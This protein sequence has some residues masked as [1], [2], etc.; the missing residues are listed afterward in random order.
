MFSTPGLRFRVVPLRCP[1]AVHVSVPFGV[2]VSLAFLELLAAVWLMVCSPWWRWRQGAISPPDGGR[3]VPP[4]GEAQAQPLGVPRSPDPAKVRSTFRCPLLTVEGL[5][6]S[7]RVL[8]EGDSA[9]PVIGLARHPIDRPDQARAG[10]TDLARRAPTSGRQRPGDV[11]CRCVNCLDVLAVRLDFAC[12]W[13]SVVVRVR[14]GP[15]RQRRGR[16]KRPAQRA[17]SCSTA[18]LLSLLRDRK[19]WRAAASNF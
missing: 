18:Q 5:N 12:F 8:P 16:R 3:E 15:A 2:N 7:P 9:P 11:V 6:L 4:P 10:R 1:V 14:A 19:A 13:V 17:P